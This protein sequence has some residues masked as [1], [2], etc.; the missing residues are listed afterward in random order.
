MVG[1]LACTMVAAVSVYVGLI[2]NDVLEEEV[3]V[4]A[5]VNL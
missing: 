5:A 3:V 1:W 2:A 4:A